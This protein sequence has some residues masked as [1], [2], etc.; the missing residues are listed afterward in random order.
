TNVLSL[1]EQQ[2][3]AL[4][5]VFVNQPRYAILDEATSALDVDNEE[6]VYQAL[7][8]LGTTYISVGHRPSLRRYHRQCLE[9]QAEGQW[10][11]E[12]LS[13]SSPQ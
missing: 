3:V 7:A 6:M 9:I 8:D 1:G 12:A 5:R 11:L 13:S 4:A 10:Q 2:R